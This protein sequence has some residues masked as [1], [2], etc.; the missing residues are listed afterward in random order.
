MTQ[1]LQFGF[2][3]EQLA[4][5]DIPFRPDLFAGQTVVISGGGGGIGRATAWMFGRLGAKVAI[6]G[7][8]IEKLNET[9]NPMR[10]AG[11]VVEPYLCN[12]RRIEE[13]E[14]LF[15]LVTGRFGGF[16]VLVN[17]A[18]GQYPQPAI[19]FTPKGWNAVIETNLTGTWYMMQTAARRWM[20]AGRPGS[21]INVI[22][23]VDRGM[24]GVA[25]T[26]A[27]RAGVIA[28]S[29]TVA[30]EWAPQKIRINCIAPG[31]IDTEGQKVYSE[32]S[33]RRSAQSNPMMRFGDAFDVADAAV[34]FSGPS[35]KFVTGET[36]IVDG[37]GVL[38]GEF[39][40]SDKPDYFKVS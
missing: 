16:D 30:V 3:N 24:P 9:A 35:G 31:A 10:D 39:W 22:A 15:D 20:A 25:H 13:V 4:N 33:R 38:W 7:R 40:V 26:C 8:N 37:G 29:K 19:D 12:I 1:N 6:C 5:R 14:V 17:S 32:E 36:L 21:I 34:Y 18:G 27:A 23:V 11:L 2:T 28:L